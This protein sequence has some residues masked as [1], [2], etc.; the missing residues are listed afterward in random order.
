MLTRLPPNHLTIDVVQCL[1]S[2]STYIELEITVDL[3]SE[4]PY[5]EK[6]DYCGC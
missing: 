5:S 1:L 6:K 4:G 2:G 3:A